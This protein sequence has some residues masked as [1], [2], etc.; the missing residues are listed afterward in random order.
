MQSEKVI[1]KIQQLKDK[2][3]KVLED[4]CNIESPSNNKQAVDKVNEYFINLAKSKGWAVEVFEF[5]EFG[6]VV[7][8]TLN[9][10]VKKQPIVYSGHIDTVHPIGFFGYPPTKVD[11]E[12][13]KIYGP[14]AMDCKGGVV[15]GFLALEAL[16][17]IGYTDRPVKVLL[18]SNEEIGSGLKNKA[19]INLICERV[20]DCL[21]FFNLEGY[22]PFFDNKVCLKRKGIAGFKFTVQGIATHS[23]Y[24]AMRGANAI[25]EASHKI[26]EINELTDP[27]GA[28]CSCNIINAGTARNTVPDECTFEV[29]VRYPTMKHYEDVKKKLLAIA[30]KVFIKG[31]TTKVEQTN[32]RSA[33]ELNEK[34]LNLLNALNKILAKHGIHTLEY[35]ERMGGSD[36]S[37]VTL[38]GV[39]CVDSIGIR[40]DFGHSIN[41]YATLSSLVD[42]ATKLALAAIEL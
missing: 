5:E 31:C 13:D 37:D 24:C 30:D 40:G 7:E 2:Y 34:N 10:N 35:S 36:A 23:S 17:E 18:Q 4:V 11:Y 38:S 29:D 41:E 33:M 28:T 1:S 9:S 39:A 21:A 20:K 22:E 16:T 14:G 32:A 12:N 26:I 27:N 6:N 8:I 19:T 25:V 15:A 42:S 3:F